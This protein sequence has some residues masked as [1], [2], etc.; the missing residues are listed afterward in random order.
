MGALARCHL[1]IIDQ[2]GGGGPA[3]PLDLRSGGGARAGGCL[4]LENPSRGILPPLRSGPV[5]P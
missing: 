5:A 1:C 4:R 3:P 2:V